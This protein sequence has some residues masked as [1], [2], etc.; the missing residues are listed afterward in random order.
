MP[1]TSA[2]NTFALAAAQRADAMIVFGDP[3]TFRYATQIAALAAKHL[4]PAIYLFL[5]FFTNG[6]LISYGPI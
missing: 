1:L 6:G 3:L 2:S 4:L 5:L